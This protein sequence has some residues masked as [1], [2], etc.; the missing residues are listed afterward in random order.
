M[1]NFVDGLMRKNI[2]ETINGNRDLLTNFL[3]TIP[4]GNQIQRIPVQAVLRMMVELEEVRALIENVNECGPFWPVGKF[5]DWKNIVDSA[6]EIVQTDAERAEILVRAF[7]KEHLS[8]LSF[9]CIKSDVNAPDYAVKRTQHCQ[10]HAML[11]ESK[12]FSIRK[13]LN[14]TNQ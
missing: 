9:A 11:T 6:P 13:L 14:I 10:K 2:K 4:V 3:G 12:L 7:V 8:A 5:D 1:K